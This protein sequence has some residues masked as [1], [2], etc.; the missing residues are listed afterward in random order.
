VTI[1]GSV[2]AEATLLDASGRRIVVEDRTGAIEVLIPADA[3][4][5]RLGDH[6]RATGE[7]GRA[8]GAPRLRAAELALVGH[9]P[10]PT[11]RALRGAPGPAHEWRL[12][13]TSGTVVAI[14]RLG[15]RWRAELAV[16]R[17]R[18][19]LNGLA[20]AAIPVTTLVEGRAATVVG[21]VRRPYPSA[22]DRRFTIIPRSKTDVALGPAA[23]PS[24]RPSAR[25]A[26]AIDAAASAGAPLDVDLVDLGSHVGRVVRVGGLVADLVP[27]GL[28]LDDGTGRAPV[29]LRDGAAE[30]LPLLE[31]GDALNAIGRVERHGDGFQVVV[32]DPAGLTRVG[33]PGEIE[34]PLPGDPVSS[35]AGTIPPSVRP[36]RRTADL[37]IPFG[38][39][40]T[41]M[42]G[43]ASLGLVSLGSLAVTLLRRER[44]RRRLGRR[45]AGR[46]AA[47]GTPVGATAGPDPGTP[48]PGPLSVG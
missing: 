5:P 45:I 31:P 15:S 39:D 30:Y 20:G 29:L 38:L 9:G 25:P 1:E 44:A 19:V 41:S 27:A 40:P 26:E 35:Q 42:A 18:V 24:T 2:T 32:V 6:V 46:L 48:G 13:R 36:G 34:V 3:T 43:I 47:L 14:V 7:I 33:D 10:Q 11:P 37:A 16:G 22:S 12:V 28:L 4:P 8:Y 21:I 17:D 23:G